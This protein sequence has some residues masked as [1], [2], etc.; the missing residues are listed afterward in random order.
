MRDPHEY[1]NICLVRFTEPKFRKGGYKHEHRK[2]TRSQKTS[3]YPTTAIKS[4]TMSIFMFETKS[5]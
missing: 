2:I 3:P 1:Q 5:L 4:S